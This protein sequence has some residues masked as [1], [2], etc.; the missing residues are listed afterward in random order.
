MKLTTISLIVGVLLLPGILFAQS[1]DKLEVL[2]ME[3]QFEEAEKV[4]LT[5]LGENL[6]TSDDYSKALYYLG[7]CKLNSGELDSSIVTFKQGL[8]L[9]NPG[10]KGWFYKGLAMIQHEK[11]NYDS[12]IILYEEALKATSNSDEFYVQLLIDK[13]AMYTANERYQKASKLYF[14]AQKL[15]DQLNVDSPV[16]KQSMHTAIGDYYL[17]KNDYKNAEINLR[18]AF[19]IAEKLFNPQ[20]PTMTELHDALGNTYI[21]LEDKEKMLYHYKK[22]YEINKEGTK[23]GDYDLIVANNSMGM[24]LMNAGNFEAAEPYLSMA[25]EDMST[26]FGYFHLGVH[27]VGMNAGIN[28]YKLK[29]YDLAKKYLH[30]S[31]EVGKKAQGGKTQSVAEAAGYLAF[32]YEDTGDFD[33]TLEHY[34]TALDAN[35]LYKPDETLSEK[36]EAVDVITTSFILQNKARTYLE[37]YL[38]DGDS[39]LLLEAKKHA[40]MNLKI[41]QKHQESLS[42]ESRSSLSYELNYGYYISSDVYYHL[43]EVTGNE[44]YAESILNYAERNKSDYLRASL[45]IAQTKAFSD[46]PETLLEF[47]TDLKVEKEEL[48]VKI[49]KGENEGLENIPW[50]SL[51]LVNQK[52]DSTAKVIRTYI[53]PSYVYQWKSLDNLKNQLGNEKAILEFL[54]D[55]DVLI[56]L[57][58]TSESVSISRDSVNTLV[59]QVITFR[60]EIQSISDEFTTRDDLT[61]MLTSQLNDLPSSINTLTIVPDGILHYLP[62]DLLGENDSYLLEKY[63]IS[64]SNFI[65]DN[66]SQN[67]A[68][69]KLLSYAPDFGTDQLASLDVVRSDLS[70]IPGAF[71]EVNAINSLFNGDSFTSAMATE[72]SFKENAENYG[73]IHMATHAIVD[74]GDP[75]ISRLVFNLSTDSINDGYLHA[76]EIYNMDLNAKLVT[77]SACNTGFGKIERGEGVKSLSWAFAYAG[78]PSTVVSLWPAADKSTPELMKYFY[79][80]LKDGQPKDLALNN[81]R[82][83]YLETA[84]GRARHPFYWGGF[85]MIGDNSPIESQRNLLVWMIPVLILF[86]LIFT[87]YRR[88]SKAS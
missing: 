5:M 44:K 73:I 88:Q 86:V 4:A 40:D 63:N 30:E 87:I 31:I 11:L 19:D 26:Y 16:L 33:K 56:S 57:L 81:A 6:P 20:H 17:I 14:Q 58:L 85:V 65:A 52:L 39:S 51:A 54:F 45:G 24:S 9:G 53:D 3:L 36:T 50:D 72:T 64:Y 79:Q 38:I 59:D 18:V 80:N 48:K 71:D 22:V 74:D 10:Y 23:K 68:N 32:A 42:P 8:S 61:H 7:I 29:N 55:D 69:N 70:A 41:L 46:I 13:G 21:G 83:M 82:K 75:E 2:V 34:E 84:E 67:E 15:Y 77:L 37:K 25:Y 60:E 49:I 47:E 35:M 1:T 76:Y 62:F 28:H 12:A 66:I 43:Y 27:I 78:V